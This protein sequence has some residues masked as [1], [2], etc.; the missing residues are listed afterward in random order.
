MH[1]DREAER[2][3]VDVLDL[4]PRR[5]AIGG[6]EDTVV[7]LHPERIGVGQALYDLMRILRVRFE[8]H[9]RRHVFGAHPC[10]PDAPRLSAVARHPRAAARDADD[11]IVRIARVY[12]NRVNAGIVGAAAE[13]HFALRVVPQR[14]IQRPRVAAVL[15]LEQSARHRAAPDHAALVRA[16]RGERP[17]QLERPVDRLA[18]VRHLR[19]V[20]VGHRRIGRRADL[21][22]RRA[23]IMRSMELGAEMS[24]TERNHEHACARVVHRQRTVVAEKRRARDAPARRAACDREQSLARR[25]MTRGRPAHDS[26]PDSA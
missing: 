5:G 9:L 18:V 6:S 3:R 20:A 2:R 15:R 16:S 4:G 24:V 25:D 26:P 13:P 22:P 10:A 19:R 7:M 21:L 14:A 12:A 23:F 17:Y 8:L 11:H 1:G